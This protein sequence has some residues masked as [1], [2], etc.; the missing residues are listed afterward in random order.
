[1]SQVTLKVL[2]RLIQLIVPTSPSDL[3]QALMLVAEP[4]TQQDIQAVDA[5]QRIQWQTF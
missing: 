1:M 4:S 2:F 5:N 3:D